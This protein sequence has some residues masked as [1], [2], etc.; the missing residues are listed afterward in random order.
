MHMHVRDQYHVSA[1]T[2][3]IKKTCE[4]Y[5]EILQYVLKKLLKTLYSFRKHYFKPSVFQSLFSGYSWIIFQIK[6]R[7]NI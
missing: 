6:F 5:F 4:K 1:T 7:T 3:N 2:R